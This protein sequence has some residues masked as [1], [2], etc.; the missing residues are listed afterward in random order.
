MLSFYYKYGDMVRWDSFKETGY[1][2]KHLQSCGEKGLLK[3]P[4]QP[5]ELT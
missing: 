1:Y 5:M 4:F 2:L 3:L